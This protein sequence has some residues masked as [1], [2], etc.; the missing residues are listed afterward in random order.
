MRLL[1]LDEAWQVTGG[2]DTIRRYL[3]PALAA[4]TEKLVW[5]CSIQ[6]GRHNLEDFDRTNIEIVGLHPPT[7]TWQGLTWAGVRRLPA[8]WRSPNLHTRLSHS[9]LRQI[10][11]RHQ[12]THLFEI[13]IHHQPFPDL[14]IPSFGIVHDLGFRGTDAPPPMEGYRQWLARGQ[15]VLTDS[16]FT[17]N[18]LLELNP[19]ASPRVQTL[20]LPAT[21]LKSSPPPSGPNPWVRP[22]PM[23]FY[24]SRATYHKGHDVL[25][26]ALARLVEEGVR[27][28]CYLT[29]SGTDCLFN[30]EP[31][32]VRSINDARKLCLPY[33][34]KMRD[35]VTLLGRQPWPA[36]EQ[37]YRA[38][39][40]IVFPTRFEGFGLPLSEALSW[41]R[42]VVASQIGPLVEQVTFLK[43]EEQVRWF[44]SE[45]ANGLA[46][47]L[48]QVLTNRAPFPPFTN[49]LR[50]RI[51]AWNWDAYACR[52]LEI[53]SATSSPA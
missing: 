52:L 45:D 19:S 5:A 53:I 28:H 27:F 26:A 15:G 6:N 41:N 7:Q 39:N 43:A 42:P 11:R 22:E 35:H 51:T 12:L 36:V 3:L 23:I 48:K 29:G 13:C 21:P 4:Q 24:P 49:E 17:R 9:Y 30:D 37:I 16:T 47:Q 44:P 20:L 1:I 10:C 8:A 18:E 14:R 33:R 34:E 46:D 2:V 31:S 32:P 38:A 50:E 40:L 25:F